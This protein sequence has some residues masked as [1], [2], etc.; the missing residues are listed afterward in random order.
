MSPNHHKVG[1]LISSRSV[2][3]FNRPIAVPGH[4]W[5]RVRTVDTSSKWWCSEFFLVHDRRFFNWDSHDSS[6]SI[7]FSAI[8]ELSRAVDNDT[9]EC[10][11][12]RH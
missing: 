12:V 3:V 8:A 4:V 10:I 2:S 9:L 11:E 1:D 7:V 6:G 5:A